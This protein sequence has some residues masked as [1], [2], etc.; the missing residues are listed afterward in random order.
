MLKKAFK[1][2]KWLIL[3]CVLGFVGIIMLY[4]YMIYGIHPSDEGT[5]SVACTYDTHKKQYTSIEITT[6][7]NQ[8]RVIT[9]GQESDCDLHLKYE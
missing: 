4:V 3:I 8:E 7:T 2:L 5:R 1:V 9:K 6:I